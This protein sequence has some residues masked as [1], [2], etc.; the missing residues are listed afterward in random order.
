M[1][2]KSDGNQN[3]NK[4]GSN[5]NGN[6]LNTKITETLS[7]HMMAQ[8]MA[9][10]ARDGSL[11]RSPGGP[12]SGL[13]N[14]IHTHMLDQDGNGS[15]GS[16]EDDN[17]AHAADVV[18]RI[19]TFGSMPSYRENKIQELLRTTHLK[20]VSSRP[21][22]RMMMET[23]PEGKRKITANIRTFILYPLFLTP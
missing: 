23:S 19:I 3:N 7:S 13:L 15:N 2:S 16:N 5:G 10:L 1:P 18:S 12:T 8:R 4:K 6:N 21:K 22:E 14:N 17:N 11:H 20:D 9:S